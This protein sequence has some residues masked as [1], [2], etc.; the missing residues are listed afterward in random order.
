M[1]KEGC[2]SRGL[3]VKL[4]VYSA[5]HAIWPVENSNGRLGASH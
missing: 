5:V 2:L 4:I 3:I 1:G